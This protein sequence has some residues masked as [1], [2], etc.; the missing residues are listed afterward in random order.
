[1]QPDRLEAR[2]NG[3]RVAWPHFTVEL[4][5]ERVFARYRSR[6]LAGDFLDVTNSPTGAVRVI[7]AVTIQI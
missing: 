5:R 7:Q 1:M 4:F 3:D 6:L 2:L